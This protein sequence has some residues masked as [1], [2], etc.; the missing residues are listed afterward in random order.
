[1]LDFI[2]IGAQKAGSTFVMQC[3]QDHPALFMPRGET[4]F[5]Q[6]PDYA[7][8]RLDVLAKEVAAASPG[9]L[10][11]IK[12]PNYLGEP[13]VP[14][15]IARHLPSA[16]L[17]AVIREPVS[18][19]ISGYF[20]YLR[21]GFIPLVPIERGMGAVLNGDWTDPYP[22][23]KDIL[24]YGLYHEHLQRYLDHFPASQLKIIVLDDVK[25]DPERVIQQLYE[26][27]GV[28]SDFRP[29]RTAERPM[30]AIYSFKRL[31]ILRAV[32]PLTFIR[33][34]DRSRIHA[35]PGTRW[36]R[37]AII[38]LD[39]HVLAR[40]LPAD[41]PQVPQAL[42]DQLRAYYRGDVARLREMLNHPLPGW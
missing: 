1:M 6:T 31:R 5:F 30:S 16:K 15:R 27:L 25:K 29:I 19:A 32:Q 26:F 37:K 42:V 13:D 11:G 22:A 23:S 2:V 10:R 40:L 9:Q 4:P 20:H 12:R 3:L 38:G 34:P 39:R 17:I 24:R 28:D 36:L 18:R 33:T 8:D 41:K 35:R 14:E 7:P 21:G